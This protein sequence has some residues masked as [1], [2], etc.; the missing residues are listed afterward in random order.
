MSGGAKDSRH[1][2]DDK[3]VREFWVR[4][5]D[6]EVLERP[7]TQEELYPLEILEFA[8]FGLSLPAPSQGRSW[9]VRPG[10]RKE[11]GA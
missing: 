1:T 9:E 5:R 2:V 3:H 11:G 4:R 6:L 8:L 10:S 7:P